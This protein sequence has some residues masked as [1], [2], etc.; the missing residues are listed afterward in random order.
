[1]SLPKIFDT[2]L[3][4]ST[5]VVISRASAG[6][7]AGDEMAFELTEILDRFEQTDLCNA[8]I[9]LEKSSYFGTSMLQVMT[10][11]W[12]RVGARGGKMALCNLSE[13]GQEILHITR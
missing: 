12:K 11:L 7:L 8:V 9:D 4:G 6:S 3:E 1:M 5:L 10:A 13:T 2:T